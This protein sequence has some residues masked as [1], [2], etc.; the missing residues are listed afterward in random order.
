MK[1]DLKWLA[2]VALALLTAGSLACASRERRAAALAR[3]EA[4]AAR[5]DAA[6][7]A[8]AR[9][10]SERQLRAE[11]AAAEA[12]VRGFAGALSRAEQAAKARPVTVARSSTGALTV[13]PPAAPAQ[14]AQPDCVLRAGDR[15]RVDVAFAELRTESGNRVLVQAAQASRVDLDGPHL[16]FG[17]E[18]RTDLTRYLSSEVGPPPRGRIGVGAL[19]L[20]TASG[21]SAGA[22][23]A[24]PPF[25]RFE[26]S[27]GV[28][29]GGA[30]RGAI[31]AALARF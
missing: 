18:L 28:F 20:C 14:G 22:V 9:E 19:A 25:G 3:T 12:E 13:E 15:G 8:R 7:V 6:G 24:A 21:C 27:G 26:L 4:E 29:S 2:V 30:G 10:A 23:A 31:L 5:L 11:V 1:I 17:G 16:L